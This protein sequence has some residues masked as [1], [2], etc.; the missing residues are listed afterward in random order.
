[1]QCLRAFGFFLEFTQSSIR[2]LCVCNFSVIKTTKK[3][4]VRWLNGWFGRFSLIRNFL[5]LALSLHFV[6]IG[7]ILNYIIQFNVIEH[8]TWSS[9]RNGIS[10]V[11]TTDFTLLHSWPNM[12]TAANANVQTIGKDKINRRPATEKNNKLLRSR[13]SNLLL[14]HFIQNRRHFRLQYLL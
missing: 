13:Q 5:S 10:N 3:Y 7:S 8:S 14:F 6:R 1:M 2:H 11:H 12:P 4:A 9:H